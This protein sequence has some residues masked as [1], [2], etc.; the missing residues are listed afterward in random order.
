[1][2]NREGSSASFQRRIC[3]SF[4]RPK[5]ENGEARLAPEALLFSS[6]KTRTVMRSTTSNTYK[7]PANINF[8][9]IQEDTQEDERRDSL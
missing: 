4:L 1:M 7:H 3:P 8:R 5:P 2:R 6:H 9:K